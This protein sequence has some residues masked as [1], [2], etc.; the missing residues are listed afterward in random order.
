MGLRRIG[1]VGLAVAA[2]V[3]G[4][5][6]ATAG[7]A[8]APASTGRYSVT[9]IDTQGAA[10]SHAVAHF[11]DYRSDRSFRGISD[12]HGRIA[13]TLPVGRYEVDITGAHATGGNSD[14]TGYATATRFAHVAARGRTNGRTIVLRPGAEVS[15]LITDSSGAP[16]RGVV[17]Q[18]SP[19]F[20]YVESDDQG[21]GGVFGFGAVSVSFSVGTAATTGKTG[22]YHLRGLA[23]GAHQICVA[24]GNLAAWVG[25]GYQSSCA[26]QTIDPAPG[27][28]TTMAPQQLSLGP[29]GSLAG[30]VTGRSGGVAGVQVEVYRRSGDG[31]TTNTTRSG[32]YSLTGL[33]AGTYHVCFAAQLAHPAPR[34]GYQTSCRKRPVT[35]TAGRTAAVNHRLSVGAGLTGVVHNPAGTPVAGVSVSVANGM[36]G[37][38]TNSAGRYLLPGLAAGKYRLC[39]DTENMAPGP[40]STGLQSSCP[41]QRTTARVKAVRSAGVMTLSRGAAFSG[42]VRDSH[43]RPARGVSVTVEPTRFTGAETFFGFGDTDAHGRYRVTGAPSGRYRICFSP[44]DGPGAADRTFC[45]SGNVRVRPGVTRHVDFRLPAM[46]S[47][48]VSVQDQSGRAVAGVDVALVRACGGGFCDSSPAF[49]GSRQ[50]HVTASAMTDAHGRVDLTDLRPGRY[51]VCSFAFYGSTTA[52]APAEG[53]RDS[54]TAS[55]FTLVARANKTLSVVQHLA[56]AGAVT[57]V[58]TDSA[59]HPLAGVD[60]RV[61]NSAADDVSRISSTDPW[62]GPESFSR[63][64]A[65]GRYTIRSVAP[66]SSTVCVRAAGA[67]GGS[68]SAGYFD[69]CLGAKA[70]SHQGGTTVSVTADATATAPDLA[71]SSATGIRGKI[72]AKRHQFVAVFVLDSAGKQIAEHMLGKSGT[73]QFNRL[74][75]RSYRVCALNGLAGRG[76]CYRNAVWGGGPL[77]AKAKAV[78]TTAGRVTSGID[79]RLR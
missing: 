48:S 62:S 19:P 36:F 29:V 6:Q 66:G 78:R 17:V 56:D 9:V 44:A 52:G 63:T 42:V 23:T 41:K 30:V 14:A 7:A 24:S 71:L 60:V 26:A 45:H 79:I 25:S 40:R 3:G 50:F 12:D 73:Y 49:S 27:S 37:A 10:L 18:S 22:R 74:P 54:C 55:S 58:V 64:D 35:V 69:Q 70:G 57:G 76:R 77:P 39:F 59:G 43:G 38:V 21:G 4:G 5:V 72:I 65:S 33:A 16:L 15:G 28:N 68:S 34:Y 75:A 13:R 1:C 32:H 2:L 31:G 46:A 47:V 61:S 67:K 8:P 51:A 11:I 20:P 53:Y